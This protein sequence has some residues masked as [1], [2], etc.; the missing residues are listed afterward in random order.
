MCTLWD[1]V[2]E[3]GEKYG[4]RTAQVTLLAPTGTIGLMMGCDTTGVEPALMLVVYKKLHGG[5][6]MKLVDDSDPIAIL[7]SLSEILVTGW[8]VV[9][10]ASS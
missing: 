3:Q 6:Y 9:N 8:S 7:Y 2:I 10:D 5:G 4:F 1:Q